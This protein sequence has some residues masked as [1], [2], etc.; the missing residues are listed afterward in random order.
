M[1]G[2]DEGVL[3]LYHV[4]QACRQLVAV[5]EQ[6]MV[7]RVIVISFRGIQLQIQTRAFV[8][9]GIEVAGLA[10]LGLFGYLL[11]SQHSALQKILERR[12]GVFAVQVAARYHGAIVLLHDAAVDL[13]ELLCVK[14]TRRLR[15]CL[16]V[17]VSLTYGK[18]LTV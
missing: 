5:I 12:G 10:V 1:V 17:K 6:G 13:K 16:V 2:R 18:S 7:Y 8:P 14:Y 15:L 3:Q 4:K 9:F 11:K